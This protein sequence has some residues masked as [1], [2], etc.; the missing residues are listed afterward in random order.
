MSRRECLN[1]FALGLGGLLSPNCW[2]AVARADSGVASGAL[3]GLPHFAP[4]RSGS[5]ISSSRAA[6]ATDLFDYKP[7]L[8]QRRANN[9]RR[10][11]GLSA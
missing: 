3:S 6:V 7:L 9:C 8:N 4:K 5:F 10:V 2:V 11:R 1:R